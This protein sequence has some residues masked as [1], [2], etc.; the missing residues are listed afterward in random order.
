MLS[1]IS[2]HAWDLA[3]FSTAAWEAEDDIEDLATAFEKLKT[4]TTGLGGFKPFT[5]TIKAVVELEQLGGTP[6]V[7]KLVRTVV[8]YDESKLAV[9][10]APRPATPV[11]SQSA[12]PETVKLVI[13]NKNGAAREFTAF[14]ETKI[15]G[16]IEPVVK[17]LLRTN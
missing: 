16:R 3:K 12:F 9:A 13:S 10:T 17:K 2:Q 1:S 6:V 8:E 7:D 15:D 5:D 14:L 4:A 11:P